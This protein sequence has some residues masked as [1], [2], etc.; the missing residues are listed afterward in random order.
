MQG[1]IMRQ[2]V[3]ERL[4]SLELSPYKA[5]RD[6]GKERLFLYDLL[7][8][9]KT[10]LREQALPA[11]AAVLKC[12]VAYLEG[13]QDTP[14]LPTTRLK[15]S[16]YCELGVWREPVAA[17]MD[18]HMHIAPDHRY[19]SECQDVFQINDD[20][21]SGIHML[22]GSYVIVAT[23]EALARTGRRI[24]ESD[25]V[26]VKRSNQ[27]GHE[28]TVRLMEDT[29]KGPVLILKGRAD[30]PVKEGK[31]IEIVGLVVQNVLNLAPRL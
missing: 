19:A 10:I 23:N 2:R 24:H 17:A 12:D 31:G 21:A 30:D 9:K 20:H 11:V 5:A 29:P 26:L 4:N 16:G 22:A 7:V 13:R 27:A 1:E 3:Q 14:R 6:A 8:G 28:F 18:I 25:F 15:L